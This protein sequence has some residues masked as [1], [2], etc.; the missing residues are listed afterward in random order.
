MRTKE[1]FNKG[2]TLIALVITIIILLILAGISIAAITQTGL[3]GKAKLAKE[4][5]N[6][7]DATEAMNLK[8]TNI[9]I[10][11]Y[12]DG[13]KLPTLQYVADKLCEDDEIE[14]VK[15]E[16]QKISS[17]QKIEIGKE[18]SIF[19][20][21]KQYPY[22]FEINSNLQLASINGVKV[23]DNSTSKNTILQNSNVFNKISCTAVQNA[24]NIDVTIAP[25]FFDGK[26]NNDV[27]EYILI[28]NGEAYLSTK[29]LDCKITSVKPTTKY[30]I[31]ILGIDK[32]MGI[33][34]SENFELMSLNLSFQEAQVLDY[35]II[36]STGVCNVVYKC[37]QGSEYDYY[38]YDESKGTT[39]ASDSISIQGYDKSTETYVE[40]LRNTNKYIN[41]D[42]SV[43][44]KDITLG[45]NIMDTSG[46]D[47]AIYFYNN[48]NTI[49][50][51]H[52]FYSIN[53]NVSSWNEDEKTF[54][55]S[56]KIVPCKIKI[57]EGTNKI[58]LQ[59]WET[60]YPVYLYN[61]SIEN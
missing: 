26:S 18:T 53:A 33:C 28:V 52:I 11:S 43:H 34:K 48:S 6:K 38:A 36:T 47:I 54:I 19:T 57:P 15:T 23:S 12:I 29:E 32:K 13:K 5:A 17:L 2:I 1:K 51:R 30:Q 14:Y 60:S 25:E 20:K 22:E 37:N 59:K 8:I 27:Y 39:K 16:T 9:Q 50:K 21:I 42:E 10:S 4:E 56:Y 61:I 40:M 55:D 49:I 35:P 24:V 41:I 46:S 44:N 31:S 3:F 7:S 58:G 45:V